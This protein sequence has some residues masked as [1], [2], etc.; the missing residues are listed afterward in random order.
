MGNLSKFEKIGIVLVILSLLTIVLKTLKIEQT[1][2]EYGSYL[3]AIGAVFWYRG[4]G[5]R[6]KSKKGE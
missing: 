2:S 3:A 1:I 4:W 5:E 6:K